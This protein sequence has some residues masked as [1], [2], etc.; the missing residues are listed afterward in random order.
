MYAGKFKVPRAGIRNMFTVLFVPVAK[1]DWPLFVL[2]TGIY[3]ELNLIVGFDEYEYPYATSLFTISL[4]AVLIKKFVLLIKD[5][6]PDT[7]FFAEVSA[8]KLNT[9][10]KLKIDV[11]SM[12]S[13]A[14]GRG[15][16]V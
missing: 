5:K 14:P 6:A 1:K 12:Q 2:E 16:G 4:D 7:I 3:E 9:V 15:F 11:N 8:I 10:L 13:L